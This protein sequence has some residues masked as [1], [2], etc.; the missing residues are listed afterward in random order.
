MKIIIAPDKFKGSLTSFAVCEAI[1]KGIR[2]V[3]T[4]VEII[5]FPMADGGDGFA[6]ILQHYYKTITIHCNSVDPLNRPIAASWQWN[7]NN[8]TAIIEMAVASGLVLLKEDERN[9]LK[10]SSFGTGVLIKAALD[11]GAEKIILGLGGSA[12]NDAGI[13]ILAAL[14]FQ[15]L[16]DNNRLLSPVGEN[17]LLIR[18]IIPPASLSSVSI[19]IACDVQNILYGPQ[20]AAFV[21]AP[22]KG[23]DEKAVKLLDEGLKNFASII[24]EQTGKDIATIPGTGAAGGIAAGLMAFFNVSLKK[25]TDMLI[26][27]SRIEAAIHNTDLIITGEGKMDMQTLDGKVVDKI[28]ALAGE[29]KIP[30]IAFCGIAEEKGLLM[31]KMNLIHIESLVSK[32][33]SKEDAIL[34]AETILVKKAEEVCRRN[35]ASL[36]SQ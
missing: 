31:K 20:G 13:G 35:I 16:D 12:T 23:A 17:L 3:K 1:A 18:K 22:Q 24:K 11:K 6:A 28:S 5:S 34:N 21:Y 9:A 33:I 2:R 25:G 15:F 8:K 27:A 19:E 10:T 7:E 26:H 32:D 14:G 36:F 30:V 4:S 29:N